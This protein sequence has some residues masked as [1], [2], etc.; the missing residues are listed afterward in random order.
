MPVIT[1]RNRGMALGRWLTSRLSGAPNVQCG[2]ERII[3]IDSFA[4]HESHHTPLQPVVRLP[5]TQPL[6]SC[7]SPLAREFPV[8]GCVNR[9]TTVKTRRLLCLATDAA[10][11]TSELNRGTR[12]A[13]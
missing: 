9:R 6:R 8:R 7:L 4:L 5:H 10:A 3:A 13:V 11:K 2:A 1:T 12:A